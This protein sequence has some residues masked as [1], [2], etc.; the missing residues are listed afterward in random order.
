MHADLGARFGRQLD[1]E[2]IATFV[3]CGRAYHAAV[4]Q[5]DLAR[6]GIERG[7]AAGTM[8]GFE[9]RAGERCRKQAAR[10]GQTAGS[11]A[12]E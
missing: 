7:R 5:D 4:Q 2:L 10:H 6:A 11:P 12:S 3:E 8:R 1:S 9:H